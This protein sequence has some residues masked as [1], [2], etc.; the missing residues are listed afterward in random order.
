MKRTGGCLLQ[1]VV[2]C[3]APRAAD[4]A[5]S[6]LLLAGDPR[7]A[8]RGFF[9]PADREPSAAPTL[10]ART[11]PVRGELQ[12]RQR[13]ISAVAEPAASHAL[14]EG[15]AVHTW[16]RSSEVFDRALNF[17]FRGD[18]FLPKGEG[19]W[20][21]M[22]RV[23]GCKHM[24]LSPDAAHACDLLGLRFWVFSPGEKTESFPG[25]EYVGPLPNG[26]QVRRL[27]KGPLRHLGGGIRRVTFVVHGYIF[28]TD[29]GIG[30]WEDELAAKLVNT[31]SGE[32][33]VI[34][35]DWMRGAHA[36]WEDCHGTECVDDYPVA[37]ADARVVGKYIQRLSA[38]IREVLDDVHIGC[39]GHSVGSHACGF[40]G[41]YMGLED[42]PGGRMRMSRISALDPAGPSHGLVTNTHWVIGG[43]SFVDHGYRLARLSR[44]DADFV[45][46][47]ISDPGGFGYD[48]SLAVE[49]AGR[50]EVQESDL[51]ASATFLINGGRYWA[52]GDMQPSCTDEAV[53]KGCSHHVAIN[54]YIRSLDFRGKAPLRKR[55][56]VT[57][58]TGQDGPVRWI[59]FSSVLVLG[60]C[61]VFLVLFRTSLQLFLRGLCAIGVLVLFSI[62]LIIIHHWPTSGTLSSKSFSDAWKS[63]LREPFAVSLL[64]P[65]DYCHD[66][67]AQ[68][69]LERCELPFGIGEAGS[70]S[71]CPERRLVNVTYGICAG[72]RDPDGIYL[73]ELAPHQGYAGIEDADAQGRH[74]GIAP[75]RVFAKQNL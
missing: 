71:T 70:G 36:T 65:A 55:T 7:S 41:K 30:K 63:A 54:S 17:T 5:I 58:M 33:A 67:Q 73:A 61:A 1:A 60:V 6:R 49:N 29:E 9:K 15:S 68:K 44:R 51:L 35:I 3:V 10:L 69:P 26:D 74:R 59:V 57:T 14:L 19:S 31:E 39:I 43:W 21:S 72:P 20:S 27:S 23:S 2:I 34:V 40:A 53:K 50:R 13:E 32:D 46:A 11:G 48:V 8:E 4:T 18:D 66:A 38:G 52:Q 75:Q 37:M 62:A 24:G 64:D 56:W 47:Y 22:P 16:P 28:W 45:D 12:D 25:R 42:L